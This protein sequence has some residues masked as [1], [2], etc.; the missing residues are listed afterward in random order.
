MLKIWRDAVGFLGRSPFRRGVAASVGIAAQLLISP[1]AMAD[2]PLGVF[3]DHGDV[4][5]VRHAGGAR[6]DAASQSF[7]VSGAGT[8]MWFA[9]DQFHFVWKKLTGDF[10]LRAR[11]EFL[12]E[13]V[14][15]HRK[16]GWIVRSTLDTDSP[17]VD[18]AVHG[19][20]LTSMQF[21]REKGA[22]TEQV[23][24]EARAP[25]VIQLERSGGAYTMSVAAFGEPFTA[26]RSID[27]DLGD[28]VYVG[29]FV[30]S[31]NADVVETGRFH[32]VR[33]TVPAP[34][35]FRPYQDY[36]ASRLEVMD[37]ETGLRRVLH[38]TP[39]ST[40]APNWTRDGEALVYTAMAGSTGS[41]S[42]QEASKRSTPASP[43]PTTT[44]TSCPSTAGASASVTTVRTTAA[45]RWSTR[46]R[47]AEGRRSWCDETGPVLPARLVAGRALPRLHRRTQRRVRHLQRSRG[48]GDEIRLTDSVGLDDGA[49]YSPDGRH[50]AFNSS[51]SGSM[52]LWRIRDDGGEP[53][54]LT[55]DGFQNWFPHYSPDGETIVFLSYAPDVEATDHPFYKHVYLARDARRRR[56]AAR[57]RLPLRRAGDD[58]R[59]LLVARRGGGSRS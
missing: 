19:D 44:T 17:Y 5:A 41:T 42:G 49:E 52:Q 21:R 34:A 25:D 51:R 40:Q 54:Q 39:D 14:D 2:S 53:T 4:G 31:H 16:L 33:V 50:I 43:P 28:D 27:V 57:R 9:E 8:N 38:E 48:G 6:Y 56:R 55:E 59:P 58:Q 7:E 10:V 1:G 18:V 26:S 24:S 35:D 37:V 15:P 30:C 45:S 29:L 32:N 20:G 47:S 11:V 46:C 36:Y 12:G 23:E 13:G 22:D 3:T